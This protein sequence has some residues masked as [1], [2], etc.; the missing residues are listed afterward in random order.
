MNGFESVS[1]HETIQK[2]KDTLLDIE[3]RK[4][5]DAKVSSNTDMSEVPDVRERK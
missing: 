4:K 2:Q 3:Q 5:E 1:V